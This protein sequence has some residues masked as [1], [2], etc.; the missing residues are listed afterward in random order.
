MISLNHSTFNV[1]SSTKYWQVMTLYLLHLVSLVFSVFLYFAINLVGTIAPCGYE[2][3]NERSFDELFHHF[4][5]GRGRGY[6]L[7]YQQLNRQCIQ[8]NFIFVNIIMII[9]WPI[10]LAVSIYYMLALRKRL[11]KV[12]HEYYGYP[13]RHY[14]CK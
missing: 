8:S 1:V 3:Q 11:Y 4:G 10:V 7:G 14:C 6:Q 2:H 13:T 5:G 12:M 9:L